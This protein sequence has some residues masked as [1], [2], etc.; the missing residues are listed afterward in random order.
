MI[1][2]QKFFFKFYSKPMCNSCCYFRNGIAFLE[3]VFNE[4]A[5]EF[6][7]SKRGS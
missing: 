7:G 5:N 4:S 2:L 6:R 3:E 1:E